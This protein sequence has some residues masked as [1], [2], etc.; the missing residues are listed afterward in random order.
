MNKTNPLRIIF[1]ILLWFLM[2]GALLMIVIIPIILLS[3]SSVLPME[4]DVNTTCGKI[5]LLFS[6]IAY[7]LFFYAILCLK[8]SV[9][10]I[11]NQQ[12]SNVLLHKKLNQSGW[13]FFVSALLIEIPPYLAGMITERKIEFS[14]GTAN[15]SFLFCLVVGL[16]LVLLSKSLKN[17]YQYVSN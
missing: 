12:F 11:V 13:L 4:L 1:Y 15:S 7:L 10:F 5:V 9:L 14:F 16:F 3:G 8:K 6:E 17:S 2:L